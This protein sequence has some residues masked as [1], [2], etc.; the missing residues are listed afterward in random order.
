M[1]QANDTLDHSMFMRSELLNVLSDVKT[2][3]QDKLGIV[4][5]PI[6]Q[7]IIIGK[8]SVGK[9]RLIEALAGEQFT[10]VSGTL[11]SRRPTIIEFRN[12]IANRTSKW[13][14]MDKKTNKWEEMP[15]KKVMSL[16]SEAHESLGASVTAEPVYVRIESAHCVDMQVVDLPGFREF[17]IDKGKEDL[18][19]QIDTLNMS[20]MSDSRNVMVCVEEAGDAANMS[21]LARCKTI[22]PRFQRTVLVRNKLDKYYRD[23]TNENVNAWLDGYG[24]LPVD[25]MK[26]CLTLPH[27]NEKEPAPAPFVELRQRMD[28]QDVLELKTRGASE[29][30]MNTIGFR[31]FSCYMEQ[32]IER[33]FVDAIGPVVKKLRELKE[34]EAE[35]VAFLKDELKDTNPETIVTTMRDCGMSFAHAL[36]HVMEGYVNSNV[37]RVTL[38]EELRDFHAFYNAQGVDW[39]MLPSE[40]FAGLDDY[41]E[42]LKSDLQIAAFDIEVNGGAQFR[43][44]MYETE[45]FLR[46]AEIGVQ[47]SKRDVV[48]ARGVSMGQVSWRDVIVKLLSNEAHL[49]MKQRVQY[50]AH[51]MR[52]FFELQ[53]DVVIDFMS[54]LKG[55][56]DEHMYSAL[57]TKHVKLMMHNEMIKNLVF[58]TFDTVVERQMHQ[59]L[60]LFSN[61]MTSTFSNPWV[62]LKKNS[63]VLEDSDG[64]E[65]ALPSFEDTKARIPMEIGTRSGIDSILARWIG[66]IPVEATQ[67][68]EAVEKVQSLVN[69][70]F[71]FI[72]SQ[73][74]DQVELFAESFF[75]LPLMRKM[76]EDMKSIELNDVDKET[77]EVRRQFLEQTL[78]RHQDG[79]NGVQECLNKL[80]AFSMKFKSRSPHTIAFTHDR[81]Q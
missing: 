15:V 3:V 30:Y 34:Q 42:Y 53:K 81:R 10:F 29:K 11:G 69:K 54:G 47:T 45:V 58:S 1:D 78:K 25:L 4:D 43:R 17:A 9:S 66:D 26:F 16:L 55:S 80:T 28:A 56:A 8:Q 6:P 36:N 7:F 39:P 48:Q 52:R 60:D 41:I 38:E 19:R 33:M 31:N 50:V 23:L 14:V 67:M 40:D 71:A 5:F 70:T 76:E 51:R 18:A 37:G 72:R 77:Y 13:Q 21:T 79:L 46:F 75:K 20:F 63:T 64:F 32:R 44:L 2:K 65:E 27:W 68:D 12:V 35:Q 74:S 57:Y 61:T 62:F 22:D 49:P 73:I 24:D 59:F